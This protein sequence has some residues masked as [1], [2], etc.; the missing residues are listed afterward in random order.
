MFRVQMNQ[1]QLSNAQ[2]DLLEQEGTWLPQIETANQYLQLKKQSRDLQN[3]STDASKPAQERD[4]A[5]RQ[6]MSV[7]S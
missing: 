4:A 2:Q 3:I 5:A 6:L 1:V 7:N